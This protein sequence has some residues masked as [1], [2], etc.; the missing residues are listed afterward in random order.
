MPSFTYNNAIPGP[1]DL[2]SQSQS[3]I[4]VN[5]A[6]IQ[7]LV[8]IDH[9]D[10]ANA[11]AGKHQAVHFVNQ[12]ALPTTVGSEVGIYCYASTLVPGTFS[13]FYQGQNVAGTGGLDIS[14]SQKA[15]PGFS[16]L[17]SGMLMQWG[18]AT[19]TNATTVTL[20]KQFPTACVFVLVGSVKTAAQTNAVSLNAIIDSQHFTASSYTVNNAP[21][22]QASTIS[23]LAIGY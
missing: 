6:S 3:D 23:Y 4:Q 2:L 20:P 14:S 15:S 19:V 8:D 18:T 22:P 7:S 5:F 17:S 21:T 12:A 9:V 11:N 10:F 1:N 16:A 13:L